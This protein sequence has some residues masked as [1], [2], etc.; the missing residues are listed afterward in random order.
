MS[1]SCNVSLYTG[2]GRKGDSLV[3]GNT[4]SVAFK[5]AL[6]AA[7]RQSARALAPAPSKAALYKNSKKGQAR[8]TPTLSCR[9]GIAEQQPRAKL[10]P[11]TERSS[12]RVRSLVLS[13]GKEQK[14][15]CR[16]RNERLLRKEKNVRQSQK[17]ALL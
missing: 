2:S 6:A 17:A 1:L 9:F 3:G 14:L 13:S 10:S 5:S 12:P 16:S 8:H 15:S 7:E 4:A 11:Y